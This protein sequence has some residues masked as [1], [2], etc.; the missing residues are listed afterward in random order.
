MKRLNVLRIP[1]SLT[2]QPEPLA[3]QDVLLI[4]L[5]FALTMGLIAVALFVAR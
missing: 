3:A 4:S 5:A 2:P 1:R